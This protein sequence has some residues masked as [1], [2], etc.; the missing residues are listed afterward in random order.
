MGSPHV[1][2]A[3]AAVHW[4]TEEQRPGGGWS[5]ALRMVGSRATAPHPARLR[6][7][8]CTPARWIR[9]EV[10]GV[11]D[12]WPPLPLSVRLMNFRRALVPSRC[13][14][15]VRREGSGSFRRCGT[16]VGPPGDPG[17]NFI[18]PPWSVTRRRDQVTRSE[19]ERRRQFQRTGTEP[20]KRLCG[21]PPNQ[22]VT[23]G[24]RQGQDIALPAPRAA[25]TAA[26]CPT[27]RRRS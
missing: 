27:A 17:S 14:M 26:Q 10:T 18:A 7:P 9:Q 13:V 22:S 1:H 16:A 20:S 6:V 4:L 2:L 24:Y 8:R 23:L 25:F 15:A 3:V 21:D 12:R 5:S 19:S 11:L